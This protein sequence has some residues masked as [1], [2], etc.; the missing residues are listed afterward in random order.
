MIIN[1]MK[2][3][4]IELEVNEE[5]TPDPHASDD[6]KIDAH[7]T[8]KIPMEMNSGN[9]VGSTNTSSSSRDSVVDLDMNAIIHS[10]VNEQQVPHPSETLQDL[11]QQ[12]PGD[13]YGQ[14]WGMFDMAGDEM[15][16]DAL[17]GEYDLA[18]KQKW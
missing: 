17:F 16:D 7:G 6:P 3:M 12:L 1:L 15:F 2:K 18:V 9:I 13:G 14:G 8:D 5:P 4:N 10:F 11:Q